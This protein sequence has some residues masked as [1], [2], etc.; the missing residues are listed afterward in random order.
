MTTEVYNELDRVFE[1]RADALKGQTITPQ[2]EFTLQEVAKNTVIYSHQ[3]RY[4]EKEAN[5]T[6]KTIDA[7]LASESLRKKDEKPIANFTPDAWVTALEK[8]G[9]M[10]DGQFMP[11][12]EIEDAVIKMMKGRGYDQTLDA[13]HQLELNIVNNARRNADQQ[14][15]YELPEDM[16]VE[17]AQV[18]SEDEREAK[19]YAGLTPVRFERTEAQPKPTK[20]Q[21]K[22]KA[23][24]AKK[25]NKEAK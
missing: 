22:K 19:R 12:R 1:S 5:S 4:G 11:L 24:T 14:T 25:K 2:I 18:E 6:W 3:R 16:R 8:A 15:I 9:V 20:P 23:P 17:C 13:A 7:M 21:I 10:K